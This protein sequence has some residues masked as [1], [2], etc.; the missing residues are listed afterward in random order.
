MLPK[1]NQEGFPQEKDTG[2]Y[3]AVKRPIPSLGVMAAMA[4]NLSP[5][6]ALGT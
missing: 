5:K 6:D 4:A 3:A 2:K 1:A